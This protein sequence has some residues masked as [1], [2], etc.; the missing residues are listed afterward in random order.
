MTGLAFEV[1]S[2][3]LL[4]SLVALREQMRGRTEEGE[5]VGT[6]ATRGQQLIRNGWKY[7]E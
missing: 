7:Y 1:F 5:G 3:A 2:V 4:Q 6:V